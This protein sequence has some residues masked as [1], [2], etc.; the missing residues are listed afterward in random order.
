MEE[1]TEKRFREMAERA[2]SRNI[3]LF[4]DFLD[5]NSQ[6]ILR[7][8]LRTLPP[9]DVELYGGTE[10][11]ERCIAGFGAE[12]EIF[13]L[14]CLQV[15]PVNQRF[16]EK[17]SHRD[18]LGALMNLG[19][20]RDLIGDIV[21]REKEAWVFC[22]ERIADYIVDQLTQVRKTSVRCLKGVKPPEGELYHTIPKMVQLSSVRLDALVAHAFDMSRSD[23]QDMILGGK[24]FLS[25]LMTLKTDEVPE[26]GQIVSVR[27]CGRFRCHESASRSKK[28][29]L[30]IPVDIYV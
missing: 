22:M 19:F 9:V 10:G 23:A 29:K 12:K 7:K 11:C 4:T 17:L 21:I 3:P 28:G 26:D 2:W 16:S 15:V 8:N 30:N 20:D 14:T 25:G 24:V 27:G 18:F 13:P 6:S 1:W 5:L